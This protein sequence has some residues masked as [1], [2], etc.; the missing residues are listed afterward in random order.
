MAKKIDIGGELHS[1]ATDHKVADASEI[2]DISKGNKSQTDFNND[3]DR[4]EVEIHGTGGINSRL[5]DVEQ[6]EQIALDGGK[7]QIAQGSDF[8]NPDATK[9]AKIPT[10]G[11]IV[12]GLNDGV[13]D[14][15]KRNSIG[16]PNNDGKFTLDYILDNAN[17]LIPIGWRH[18]GMIISFVHSSDNKYVQYFLTKDEWSLNEADWQKMN[19][20]EE[21]SQLGQEVSQLQREVNG[22]SMDVS[23]G[24]VHQVDTS[25]DVDTPTGTRIRIVYWITRGCSIDARCTEGRGV[26]ANIYDTLSNALISSASIGLLQVIGEY[27]ESIS[28]TAN[29]D[30]F[31]VISLCKDDSTSFSP[32]EKASYL[33]ATTIEIEKASEFSKLNNGIEDINKHLLNTRIVDNGVGY[34][35]KDIYG[36]IKEHV[37]RI[38]FEKPYENQ[39]IIEGAHFFDI[40]NSYNGNTSYLLSVLGPTNQTEK[41]YDFV[42]PDNSDFITIGLRVNTDNV[43]DFTILDITDIKEIGFNYRT[44]TDANRILRKLPG[45]GD[46]TDQND[47][48]RLRIVY[49][50]PKGTKF[51]LSTSDSSGLYIALYDNMDFALRANTSYIEVYT[52]GYQTT[53][54]EGITSET[55]FLSISLTNGNSAITDER[56]A[57]MLASLSINLTYGLKGNASSYNE[58]DSVASFNKDMDDALVAV[59]NVNAYVSG[60]F[61]NPVA[62]KKNLS[63][64]AISDI[65]G[66]FDAISRAV[67]YANEKSTFIDYVACL[68]DIVLRSPADSIANFESS[69]E[70]SIRPFLFTVGNHDAADTVRAAI[71]ESD[72]RTKYFAQIEHKGWISNFKDANSCSWY[73]D[74]TTYKIRII[75]VFE[76]GNSQTIAWNAHYT[77]CRR[78]IPTETLQW[79]ADTLFSTPSDYSVVVL[80][81]QIPFFPATYVVNKFT[82]SENIRISLND[83]FLN[84]V[85]G[86]PFGDIVDA[87][88]NGTNIT[89]EYSSIASYELG[90][91]AQVNKDFSV[92]GSGKFICYVVGHFHGSYVFTD[93]TYPTQKTIAVPSGSCS[94]FQQKYGDTNYTPNNRHK[95]QFYIIGFDTEKKLINIA[96]IGGQITRNMVK[97]DIISLG[98]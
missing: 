89:K 60:D 75:S 46:L 48:T 78:W 20:E 68:G 50:L 12:D 52:N 35:S 17:T 8:T 11:A 74:D 53:Q 71:S 1:V 40:I 98:Y 9:R 69:F 2:K 63:I 66:T 14:V 77:Y 15:S 6:I 27:S 26:A 13:Y 56:K 64:L 94:T 21:V 18:G 92:R 73:K 57:E 49:Y 22:V 88:I 91:T 45:Y 4:H 70:N 65:H 97:R 82:I 84:T 23:D 16:G 24:D 25:S 39:S 95:D 7:A 19:L 51:L 72:A 37:Y 58:D 43:V 87:F 10:V 67:D 80:L 62:A 83:F 85:D 3:V 29:V 42:V 55:G 59:G 38:Y 33:A 61:D 32:A 54:I 96:K 31:L 76:Y 90:K 41:Y 5:T 47:G 30:G 93:N 36:L 86:N 44:Y 34:V 79:F 81:H 28:G